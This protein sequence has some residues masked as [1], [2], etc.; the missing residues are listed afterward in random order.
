[1]GM[2]FQKSNPFPMSISDN[3]TYPLQINGERN[4]RGAG[5]GVREGPDAGRRSGTR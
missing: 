3:V 2:V 5:R 4:K 1:M